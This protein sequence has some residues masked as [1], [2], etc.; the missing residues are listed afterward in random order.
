MIRIVHSAKGKRKHSHTQQ[1]GSS[2][3]LRTQAEQ[4]E[5]GCC[6]AFLGNNWE[7]L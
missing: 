5:W 4:V 6:L 1:T 2:G 3:V 7:E